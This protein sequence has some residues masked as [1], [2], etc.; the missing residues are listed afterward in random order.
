MFEE[1]I[2]YHYIPHTADA[3]FEAFGKDISEAF[4]NAAFA[5]YNIIIDTDI[6]KPVIKKTISIKAKRDF[7]LLYDFLEEFLFLLDTENFVLS[8]IESL[9]IHEGPGEYLLTCVCFGDSIFDEDKIRK[10][11]VEGNVKSVT[12]NDMNI[13][14]RDDKVYVTVVIDL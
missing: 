5:T 11:E 6:V 13:E 3:K 14:S 4:K 9:D 2:G 1:K 7:S 8:D 10:Y 12:Y